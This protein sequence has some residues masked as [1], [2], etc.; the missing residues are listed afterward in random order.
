MT[1]LDTPPS[2]PDTQEGNSKK[3]WLLPAGISAFAMVIMMAPIL[4]ILA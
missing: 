2:T 4:V 1:L 3:W